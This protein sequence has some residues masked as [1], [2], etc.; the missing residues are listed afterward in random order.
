MK[1][2]SAILGFYLIQHI[3]LLYFFNSYRMLYLVVSLLI[4]LM[5]MRFHSQPHHT[6]CMSTP[7]IN[8]YISKTEDG[9]GLPFVSIPFYIVMLLLALISRWEI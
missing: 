9:L 7:I 6:L 4:V 1:E 5:V 3:L 8:L 2:M